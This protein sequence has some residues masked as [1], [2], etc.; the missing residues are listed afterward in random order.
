MKRL[1]RAALAANATLFLSATPGIFAQNSASLGNPAGMAPNTPG[2][3]EA[4]PDN[5]H[6][7]TA[8]QLFA[9]EAALGGRAEIQAGKLASHK[10]ENAAVKEFAGKM[11]NE[12]SHGADRLADIIKPE[13]YP[14]SAELDM[15]HRVML[16]QL[17]KASGKSFDELYIRAQIMD[18]QK[19]VQLYEWII[20]NGQ[21]PRLQSYAMDTLPAIMRHLEMAKS[22]LSQ[23]TGSAP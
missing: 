13:S 15:D 14:H 21:D 20:G 12:H 17:G 7:N 19:S 9:H 5:K 22:I 8:D 3:Y 1:M 23:L 4:H 18:H 11:V 10:A 16:D 6:P 2:I